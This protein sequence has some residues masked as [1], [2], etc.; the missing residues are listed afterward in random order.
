MLC[1][2]IFKKENFSEGLAKG[3]EI[4]GLQLKKHFP[5]QTDDINELSDDISF[6]T[7]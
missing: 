7:K 1:K 6:G 4:T 5:H 3:I 2:S